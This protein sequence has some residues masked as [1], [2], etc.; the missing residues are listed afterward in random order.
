WHSLNKAEWHG[1]D[2]FLSLIKTLA[3][4]EIAHTPRPKRHPVTIDHL[5][6]LCDSLSPTNTFD[7]AVLAVA[8]CAFWGCCRFGELIIPSSNV[9]ST[10]LHASRSTPIK[11]RSQHGGSES[12]HFHIPFTKTERQ[13]GADLSFT[14]RPVLCPV[15]ALCRHLD[16]NANVPSD[17]PLFAFISADGS[18]LPMTKEWFLGRCCEIW[19][20]HNLDFIHGHSFRPGGTT[21]L[22]LRGVPPEAVAKEGHWN[23]LAFSFIPS[24]ITVLTRP[25]IHITRHRAP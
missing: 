3:T 8:L 2:K 19:K 20:W 9:F 23:S 5:I 1:G 10:R 21:E 15:D 18:R 16:L 14:S 17:A 24:M 25:L 7:A 12:V 13:R 6:A 11:Y 4:K 22:L